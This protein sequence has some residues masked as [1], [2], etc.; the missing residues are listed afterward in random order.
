MVR[1]DFASLHRQAECSG[2]DA[3]HIVRRKP[4]DVRHWLRRPLVL[5]PSATDDPLARIRLRRRVADHPHDLIP[6]RRP[7]QLEV[8]FAFADVGEVSV[9]FDEAGNRELTLEIDDLR[10][11][12]GPFFPTDTLVASRKNLYGAPA[13]TA[14]LISHP[15]V[16][17]AAVLAYPDRLTGTGLYAF[18]EA[19]EATAEDRQSEDKLAA[20]VAAAVGRENAPKY[21]QVVPALP[22]NAAG[23]VRTD[24]LQ[25]V[26]TNQVDSIDP[27]ITSEAERATVDRILNARHNMRDRFVL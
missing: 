26:A 20:Y 4:F 5:M 21:I 3:D 10:P 8:E 9:P 13:I 15:D 23:H 2:T 16:R 11:P 1:L 7:H 14:A 18:V 17:D 12:P 25:L 19:R 22:R 6:A 24:I 27:L